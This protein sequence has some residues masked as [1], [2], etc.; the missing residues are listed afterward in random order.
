MGWRL[1]RA[2][3]RAHQNQLKTLCERY[4]VLSLSLFGSAV[5][6]DFDEATSDLDFV[7]LFADRTN[8]HYLDRYLDLA[9]ALEALFH[10][11]VDLVTERSL[12]SPFFRDS[13]EREQMTIDERPGLEEAA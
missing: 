5:R 4:G 9:D 13:V 12:R 10:R 8:P 7:V 2:M 11:D 3:I 1:M 6:D